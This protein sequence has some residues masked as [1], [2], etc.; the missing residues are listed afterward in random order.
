MAATGSA[1]TSVGGVVLAADG[2]SPGSASG[3]SSVGAGVDMTGAGGAVP[4]ASLEAAHPVSE[5]VM[6][7]SVG[8]RRDIEPLCGQHAEASTRCSVTRDHGLTLVGP[9]SRMRARV[10]RVALQFADNGAHGSPVEDA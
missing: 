7:R 5:T 6:N 8:R 10:R 3:A 2:A 9:A 4:G 1:M